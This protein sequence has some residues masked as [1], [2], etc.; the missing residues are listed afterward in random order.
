MKDEKYYN[1][2]KD[3]LI[4]NEVYKKVKDY[5]KNK[6]DLE[7]YYNVGK[8]LI[9]A[10]GGKEKAKYGDQLIKRYSIKLTN[11]LGKGYTTTSLKRMRQF[12]LLI[13]K[14][15][16]LAHQLTWEHYKILIPLR[17]ENEINYYIDQCIKYNLSKRALREKIK[18]K[19][20][21]RLPDITKNKLV[22][23]EETNIT[24]FIKDPIIIKN[25]LNKE[26]IS[27]KVLQQLILDDIPF[28]LKQLGNGFTFIDNEY[29]I[30]INN[31]DNYIDLLLYNIIYN[32]YVVIELKITELKKEHIGQIEIYKNYIDEHLKTKMQNNT[33]GII[34]YK[35]GNKFLLHYSTDNNIFATKYITI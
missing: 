7:S 10:Q 22:N 17:N 5:S 29:K 35:S 1:E 27:E 15:A 28:F 26:N 11:E 19:E 8:L 21:E 2:I 3:I 33:I 9:E 25:S 30:K 13:L 24:D 32:S 12:Y 16:P 14:G 4:S 20:Y 18:Q 6:H 31:K 34:I 23:K